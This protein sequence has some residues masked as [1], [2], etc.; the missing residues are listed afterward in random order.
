LLTAAL[1]R[2]AAILM[3]PLIPTHSG[4]FSTMTQRTDVHDL[5]DA[6]NVSVQTYRTND[7]RHFFKFEFV[8]VGPVYRVY[9][10]SGMDYGSRASDA[11]ST[12]RFTDSARNLH[13]ICF[14]P[15]P[16]TLRDAF[17]V[18]SGWAENTQ[19]YIATGRTF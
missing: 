9:I 8:K 17:N 5:T 16:R 11:H 7:G 1:L 19:R 6:P 13:Y 15:E 4:A 12:H 10:L 14:D 2:G 18:A 3:L